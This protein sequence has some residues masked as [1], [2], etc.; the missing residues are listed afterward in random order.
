MRKILFENAS[1]CFS[2][3]DTFES[4]M[5]LPIIK[6]LQDKASHNWDDYD[7]VYHCMQ[8]IRAA[9]ERDDIQM[10]FHTFH[11]NGECLGILLI[12]GGQSAACLISGTVWG[13]N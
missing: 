1:D 10:H 2:V 4:T 12:S 7:E 11:R 13:K 8:L 5:L 9:E 6:N 3:S